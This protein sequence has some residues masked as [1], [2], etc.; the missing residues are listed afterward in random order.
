MFEWLSIILA[1]CCLVSGLSLSSIYWK[2]SRNIIDWFD[3][4]NIMFLNVEGS[5]SSHIT[6]A[7]ATNLDGTFETDNAAV[8]RTDW[9]GEL[10][11]ITT[12]EISN[13]ESHRSNL[14]LYSLLFPNCIFFFYSFLP[15]RIQ[16]SPRKLLYY[17]DK[18]SS[19]ITTEEVFL[20]PC[21][22][23]MT[24]SLHAAIKCRSRYERSSRLP[25]G[26]KFSFIFCPWKGF[27][28][29]VSKVV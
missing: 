2:D 17:H 12:K 15:F 11:F 22:C 10:R 28:T 25:D 9:W 6:R 29:H 20:I 14:R 1:S 18:I 13:M 8:T 4:Q 23:F 3:N 24:L 7:K 27:R 5:I 26:E 19:E 16:L 21:T